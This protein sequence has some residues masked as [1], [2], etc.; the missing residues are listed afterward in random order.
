MNIYN[1]GV[2]ISTV[3]KAEA[4]RAELRA[5]H[6]EAHA[7]SLDTTV[8]RQRLTTADATL[9]ELGPAARDHQGEGLR[10]STE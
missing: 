9:A 8:L 10:R 5:W 7:L 6:N 3:F 1:L 2:G 4:L